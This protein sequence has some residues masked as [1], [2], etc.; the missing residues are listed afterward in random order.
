MATIEDVMK[1][2]LSSEKQYERDALY[3]MMMDLDHLAL[4]MYELGLQ[5]ERKNSKWK[6]WNKSKY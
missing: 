3:L 1:L 4:R 6:I 2:S 5:T